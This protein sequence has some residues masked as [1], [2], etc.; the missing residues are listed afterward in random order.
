M[1]DE[2][3]RNNVSCG[4]FFGSGIAVQLADQGVAVFF[5]PICE[6][7][8]KAFDLLPGGLAEGLGAAEGDG[9][10]LHQVGIELVLA[11][12][13]AEAVADFRATVVSILAIDR[14]GWKLLRFARCRIRFGE[15]ADLLDRTDADTVG[16]AQR[17]VDRSGLG[18]P[19]LGAVYQRRD[20][21]GIRIAVTD[22]TFAGSGFENRGS[23]NP[24]RPFGVA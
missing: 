21:G 12:Q 7:S 4:A 1:A 19:H 3:T 24:T 17:P 14:L 8:H 2:E 6:M 15:R 13:L 20:I 9:V 5:G 22:E 11:D 23:E 10:G 16:L 18:H